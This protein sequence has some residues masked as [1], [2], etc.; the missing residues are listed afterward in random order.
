LNV[1][2]RNQE[3]RNKPKNIIKKK[4]IDRNVEMEGLDEYRFEN[5][6]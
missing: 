5:R 6:K 1:V 3:I 4:K 2:N